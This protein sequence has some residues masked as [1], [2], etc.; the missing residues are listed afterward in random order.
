[1]LFADPIRVGGEF[2]RMT[3]RPRISMTGSRK[4]T[5]TDAGALVASDEHAL[6]IGRDGPNRAR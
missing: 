6:T 4:A 5:T 2:G 1:M 3:R